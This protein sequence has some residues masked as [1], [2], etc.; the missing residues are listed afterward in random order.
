[1]TTTHAFRQALHIPW[2]DPDANEIVAAVVPGAEYSTDWI[3]AAGTPEAPNDTKQYGRQS[4]GWTE[5]TWSSVSGKPATFP[6]SAHVHPW[7]DI[8]GK[9]ATFPPSVHSHVQSEVANLETDLAGKAP[10]VHTHSYSSLTGIPATFAP[11]AHTHPQAEVTGLLADLAARVLKAG[12]TMT[13]PLVLPGDPSAP[14]QAATKA[15]V[16][17]A[18]G[19]SISDVPLDGVRYVR[20]DR[21]WVE[22]SIDC[23]TY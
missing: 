4:L 6:P 14:L 21:A 22:L 16:D 23:G 10:L 11:S 2:A 3:L 19:G 17:A 7:S 13:G 15:Y 5:V 12:D 20:K 8:T 18:T 1:M 9:P